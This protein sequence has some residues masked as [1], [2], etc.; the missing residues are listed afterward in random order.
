MIKANI[1]KMLAHINYIKTFQNLS[2]N[3]QRDALGFC[4]NKMEISIQLIKEFNSPRLSLSQ[5]D[6]TE[7]EMHIEPEEKPDDVLDDN[8]FENQRLDFLIHRER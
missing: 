8:Y 4:F 2:D 7:F 6:S 1:P 5:M 3:Q